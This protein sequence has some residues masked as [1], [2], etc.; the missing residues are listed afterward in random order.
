MFQWKEGGCTSGTG[1]TGSRPGRTPR[2]SPWLPV[3][4]RLVPVGFTGATHRAAPCRPKTARSHTEPTTS[5]PQP[6]LWRRWKTMLFDWISETLLRCETRFAINKI[7][8]P[9]GASVDDEPAG[10]APHVHSC[11]HA[12]RAT[13][14]VQA[15]RVL[16]MRRYIIS[17]NWGLEISQCPLLLSLCSVWDLTVRLPGAEWRF[18]CWSSLPPPCYLLEF[19]FKGS[20]CLYIYFSKK[21]TSVKFRFPHSLFFKW[22]SSN[23]F[24]FI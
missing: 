21:W 9:L 23:I 6:G 20:F 8:H 1:G 12:Q 10:R 13:F 11:C 17:G 16:L 2:G 3:P 15:Q 22:I 4:W 5:D 19:N 14:S 24:V 7:Q 18:H